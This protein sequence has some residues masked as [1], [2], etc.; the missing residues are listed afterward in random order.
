MSYA[1]FT[2][3]LWKAL[4][5]H[6]YLYMN[7]FFKSLFLI[8]LLYCL[9]ACLDDTQLGSAVCELPCYSGSNKT[10]GIGECKPGRPICDGEG[11]LIACE[12]ERVPNPETC[13]GKDDDCDGYIDNVVS[14]SVIGAS[15]GPPDV[16]RCSPG[17]NVCLNGKIVC[18]NT[19]P[20]GEEVCNQVDDDCNGIVDDIKPTFCYTGDVSSIRLP[21]H[22]GY[23]ACSTHGQLVC[24]GERPPEREICNRVDDDC[25]GYVD[26]GL[27]TSEQ[28]LDILISIDISG[29]NYSRLPLIYEKIEALLVHVRHRRGL[30]WAL[31][32]FPTGGDYLGEVVTD[33]T[34]ADDF[35]NYIR[36]SSNS[37]AVDEPSWDVA[38]LVAKKEHY[39]LTWRSGVRAVHISFVDEHGQTY[40]DGRSDWGNPVIT[41][42]TVA[43]A[44]SQAKQEYVVFTSVNY[45]STYDEITRLSGG[46]LNSIVD[47]TAMSGVLE[48]IFDGV[49]VP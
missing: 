44:V 22:P 29:S 28:P 34:V 27:P 10:L 5:F 20:P 25:N 2:V 9:P 40:I 48:S 31:I 12:D 43:V 11:A 36:L 15:C 8:C 17:T 6:S 46:S 13:N 47:F 24:V 7:S 39:V 23:T 35:K 32:K 21:C 42:A 1:R 45:Y 37:P 14:S 3:S 41:E 16:G 30:R 19:V 38:Y 4:L 49:C 26:D 18:V 33:F